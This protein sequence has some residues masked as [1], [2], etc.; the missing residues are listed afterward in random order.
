MD[1]KDMSALQLRELIARS[2]SELIAREQAEKAAACEK[3]HAIA[4]DAGIPLKELLAGI[5]SNSK[6]PVAARYRNPANATQTWTG[7]GRAPSWAKPYIES[8]T[9]DT[10]I[11]ASEA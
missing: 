10:T 1:L 8:G 3:I 7:R 11:I 6:K 5:Q 4:K 2:K 9:L